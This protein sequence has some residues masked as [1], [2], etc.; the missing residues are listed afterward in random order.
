[1]KKDVVAAQES[2][3]QV[4]SL[5]DRGVKKNV[6]KLNKAKRTKAR[7]TARLIKQSA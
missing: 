6:F 3:N 7:L 2:L 5:M 4:Y 1:M